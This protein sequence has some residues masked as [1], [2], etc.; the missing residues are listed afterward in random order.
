VDIKEQPHVVYG[1]P[2]RLQQ[3]FWNV[4]KN[5]IKFTPMGGEVRV[6]GWRE[7]GEV[8]VEVS[9]N[10]IGIEADALG[11]IFNAFEQENRTTTRQ[12]GGL[13]LGLTISK[14][15][16][17]LHEGSIEAHS[18]GKNMGATF[19]VKLP[20]VNAAP[21]SL[22]ASDGHGGKAGSA[23]AVK[24]LL[25]EDHK[26]SAEMLRLLLTKQGYEVEAA[27]DMT[28]GLEAAQGNGFDV[29]VSDL[30]L[31]D[32]SGTELMRRLRARGQAVPGIALSGY[33]QEQDVRKSLQAG[34]AAHLLKPV[35]ISQINKTIAAVISQA[36]AE[37][38]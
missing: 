27:G 24:I 36:V 7:N 4:I 12:F 25:V 13:G 20:V 17:E 1:D 29:I 32:G 2:V 16:V 3:M 26:D 35:D 31:P 11:T 18:D 10:G 33:G 9:D 30:S 34:F 14:A 23:G 6:R 21:V 19:R 38:V 28:A 22:P 8:V 5:A 37:S 15:M